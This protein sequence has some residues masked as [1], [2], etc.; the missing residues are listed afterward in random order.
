MKEKRTNLTTSTDRFMKPFIPNGFTY[1]TGSW[2]NGFVISDKFGNE[3]VWVPVGWLEENG[4][5]D[6]LSFNSKLGLRNWYNYDFSS[7]G[8]H[9]DIPQNIVESILYWEGFYTSRN[10]ASLENGKVVFKTGNIPLV[11][12]SY[13]QAKDFESTFKTN[14]DD[15]DH[16]LMLGSGYDSIC[17]WIIQSGIKTKGEILD[18][19]TYLGN[20]ANNDKFYSNDGLAQLLPTGSHPEWS[21]YNINDLAGNVLEFTQEQH[22]TDRIVLR[23]GHYRVNGRDYPIGDRY[24]REPPTTKVN[25]AGFRSML[26]HK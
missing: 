1:V 4:T 3:F 5:L 25:I 13:N 19:S 20:Y 2:N 11:E 23:G 24:F 26:F 16:C 6:G 9:E 8:W 10:T 17:Q 12:L 14:S 21:I 18:D 22:N 7:T 15:I